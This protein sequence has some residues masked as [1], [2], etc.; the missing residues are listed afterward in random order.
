MIGSS[1]RGAFAAGAGA[2][3]G[4][5]ILSLGVAGLSGAAGALAE[6]DFA[7]AP[8]ALALGGAD[9]AV[10]A[11]VLRPGVGVWALAAAGFAAEPAALA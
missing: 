2:V 10:E 4:G 8:A 1:W 11:A 7:A 9:L 3:A 6:A 5:W